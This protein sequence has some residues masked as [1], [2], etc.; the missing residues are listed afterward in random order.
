MIEEG[1]RYGGRDEALKGKE[2]EQKEGEAAVQEDR[3]NE[4]DGKVFVS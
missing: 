1:A 3:G 4:R 2:E